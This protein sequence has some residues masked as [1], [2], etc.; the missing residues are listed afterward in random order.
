MI[1]I[2][3]K[4]RDRLVKQIPRFQ[5]ILASAK[6]RD[7]H[8]SD[9]VTIVVDMLQYVFGFDKYT[10]IT[11][12]HAIK[13]TF[14]DLAVKI[15]GTVKY[16]IEVK[17]IGLDLKDNH[18]RQAINYGAHEGIPWIVL[19]NGMEWQIHKISFERP[20]SSELVAIINFE[21]ISHR[22]KENLM[23]IFLLCRQGI[24]KQAMEDYHERSQIVN[25]FMVA[26]IS[27]TDPV[28]AVIRRE[29]KRFVPGLKVDSDEIK[30]LLKGGVLKRDVTQGDGA[31]QAAARVKKLAAKRIRKK[32][33][34]AAAEPYLSIP[35]TSE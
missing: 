29:L 21:E 17:A 34:K 35:T 18:L 1:T 16:L 24:K 7:I 19:T 20:I 28:V 8:E 27:Q 11:S 9:T 14:C 15:D 4:V 10:E 33:K 2:P 5:K 6:N 3:K 31:D 32:K 23:Q 26:A 22:K 30:E 13:G 25:R 12:E